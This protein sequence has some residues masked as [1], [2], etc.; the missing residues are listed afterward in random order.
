M[1]TIEYKTE[2]G[3][4]CKVRFS[5]DIQDPEIETEF[6]EWLNR[7]CRNFPQNKTFKEFGKRSYLK[8]EINRK[9]GWLVYNTLRAISALSIFLHPHN[10]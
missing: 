5:I 4:L 10:Y 6:L 7:N 2:L 1:P 3:D 8:K 9:D